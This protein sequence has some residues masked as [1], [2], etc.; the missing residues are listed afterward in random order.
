MHFRAKTSVCTM[1]H[2]NNLP[3]GI[4]AG[5]IYEQIAV[6]FEPGDVLLFYLDG[7]R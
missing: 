2:G 4:R 1:V 3:L 7:S 5:K 6:A